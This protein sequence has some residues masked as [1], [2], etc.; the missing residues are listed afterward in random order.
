MQNK[1]TLF[2][3]IFFITGY[4]S[5]QDIV[6]IDARSVG[7][8]G[9]CISC[10]DIWSG[11]NNPAGLG[12]QSCFEIGINYNNRFLLSELS[13]RS[14]ITTI[15]TE[16][17]VISSSYS[18]YGGKPYNEN[19][20]SLAYGKLLCSWLAVGVNFAYH[21]QSIEAISEKFSAI[22]GQIGIIAIPV[23]G[24]RIGLNIK[25]PTASAYGRLKGEELSSGMQVG[26]SY[27]EEQSFF[28]AA[29]LNY[30][31]FKA[32]T[33]SM[34][35]EC[36]LAR[37]FSLRAGLKFP[38]SVSFSFGFGVRFQRFSIDMGFEQHSV[39]G[40]SSAFSIDYKIRQNE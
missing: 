40:L 11:V 19:H 6:F 27:S 3:C 32:F 16:F 38:A 24:L 21:L 39:L 14:V 23:K 1:C 37:Y 31:E 34:G 22:T 13:T 17:G 35:A 7:L 9:S 12:M 28:L 4:V 29:Q 8:S 25:N 30:S 18:Y 33:Y 36:F 15:P 26:I 5:A 2:I 10:S 20:L